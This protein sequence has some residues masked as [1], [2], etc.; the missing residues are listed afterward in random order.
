MTV[1]EA[2]AGMLENAMKDCEGRIRVEDL[3]SAA[4]AVTGEAAIRAVGEFDAD[5]HD[6]APGQAVMSDA[7]NNLL[8]G[9]RSDWDDVPPGSLFGIIR[10][11]ALA[12]GY[13]P[14]DFPDVGET[15]GIYAAGIGRGDDPQ[16]IWG[17]PALSVPVVNEPREQPLRHAY[18]LRERVRVFFKAQDIAVADQPVILAQALAVVLG[19][20]RQAIDPGVA[21]R[22]TL[23]TLN[24]MAKMA[25][26]T[27]KHL[28][29][30]GA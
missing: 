14:A 16:A 2:L 24:G 12:A 22:L 10:K 30:G 27:A 18:E 8:C 19:H 17:R 3:L 15:I 23:E 5:A 6:F 25:P 11:G 28:E 21:I 26:M 4:A 1:R 9:D 13:G 20:V 7:I 29:A